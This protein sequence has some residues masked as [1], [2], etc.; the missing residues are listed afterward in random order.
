MHSKYTEEV[1]KN[2]THVHSSLHRLEWSETIYNQFFYYL[3]GQAIACILIFFLTLIGWSLC[4]IMAHVRDNIWD[5]EY[6][7]VT[8]LRFNI[9][10]FPEAPPT[11]PSLSRLLENDTRAAEK[12]LLQQLRQFFISLLTSLRNLPFLLF[13]ISAGIYNCRLQ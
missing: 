11:P 2:S 5:I 8:M 1:C 12:S 3:L 10:A 9:A 4:I 13:L 7:T 6:C